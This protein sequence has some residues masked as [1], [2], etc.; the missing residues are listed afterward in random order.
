M[1]GGKCGSVVMTALPIDAHAG[2]KEIT[3]ICSEAIQAGLMVRI[4]VPIRTFHDPDLTR[5]AEPAFVWAAYDPRDM[6][7]VLGLLEEGE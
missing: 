7:R 4:Q 3:R 2:E 6:L 5:E 1:T